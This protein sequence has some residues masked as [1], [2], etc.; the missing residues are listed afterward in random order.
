[1]SHAHVPPAI[2]NAVPLRWLAFWGS[3]W[4]I[5]VALGLGALAHYS[6]TRGQAADAPPGWPVGTQ[7]SLHGQ[8]HTLVMIAHPRCGCTRASLAELN[9]LMTRLQGRVSAHVLLSAPLGFDD[10]W[11]KSE[12]WQAAS[13]IPDT[14]VRV[15]LDSREADLF[16]ARTSGQT[17]LFSPAGELLFSGGI[18]PSRGH[19]GDSVGRQRIIDLVTEGTAERDASDVFGCPIHADDEPRGIEPAPPTRIASHER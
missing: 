5:C 8:R 10:E 13:I 7:L 2:P 14:E 6:M 18:T 11:A 4:L 17:Y 9:R 3:L 1:M 15:D 12:L 19:Q 16:G